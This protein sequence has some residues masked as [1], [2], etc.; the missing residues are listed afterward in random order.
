[1]IIL[2]FLKEKIALLIKK[3]YNP[4]YKMSLSSS[5]YGKLKKPVIILKDEHYNK[6]TY[7]NIINSGSK[8]DNFEISPEKELESFDMRQ[9]KEIFLN[10]PFKNLLFYLRETPPYECAEKGID[11]SDYYFSM[12]DDFN[13]FGISFE[14][15]LNVFPNNTLYV[16]ENDDSKK[17]KKQLHFK[18][19]Y[20]LIL[21]DYHF[22]N[23]KKTLLFNKVKKIDLNKYDRGEKPLSDMEIKKR[24][25]IKD[26]K[27]V[28]LQIA[29]MDPNVYNNDIF[30]ESIINGIL[31]QYNEE[32]LY[33]Y[34]MMFVDEEEDELFKEDYK[35]LLD[36][37]KNITYLIE[38]SDDYLGIFER[39]RSFSDIFDTKPFTD[40]K[41]D[42]DNIFER[43][44]KYLKNFELVL[45]DPIIAKKL[46]LE[47]LENKK[48]HLTMFKLNPFKS[49]KLVINILDNQINY[50]EKI[51]DNYNEFIRKSYLDECKR[52]IMGNGYC[53]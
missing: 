40:F 4:L 3:L 23:D 36:M 17:H 22:K 33:R 27:N 20:N 46:F 2:V 21:N 32:L 52:I 7:D 9:I 30:F 41:P 31:E 1:M 44:M 13:R 5:E 10:H 53:I 38:G 28:Y 37:I 12:L 6:A 49:H 19:K 18:S 15:L 42:T 34:L 39:D 8:F 14:R 35:I 50:L 26:Q 45:K 24:K 51:K 48:K 16:Q 11:L 25:A 29:M 43:S 47:E